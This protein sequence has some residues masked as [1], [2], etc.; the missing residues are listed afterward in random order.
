M[1][2]W[3]ILKLKI[4]PCA[5]GGWCFW[6]RAARPAPFWEYFAPGKRRPPTSLSSRGGPPAAFAAPAYPLETAADIRSIEAAVRGADLVINATPLGL[7]AVPAGGHLIEAAWIRRE[8][9]YYDL[10][11]HRETELMRAVRAAG[12]RAVG[13]LGMLACQGARAF[14]LWFGGDPPGEAMRRAA[15]SALSADGSRPI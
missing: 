11:Y 2:S 6:A 3:T 5:T 4:S 8:A 15:Q 7:E 10:I 1:G 12:G 14:A 9:V 13:G